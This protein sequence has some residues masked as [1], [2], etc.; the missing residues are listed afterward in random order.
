MKSRTFVRQNDASRVAR[1][2]NAYGG[3]QSPSKANKYLIQS[4]EVVFSS[5]QYSIIKDLV[6]TSGGIEELQ[7][8]HRDVP[9][10]LVVAYKENRILLI[11]QYRH[12]TKQTSFELPA[13]KTNPNENITQ[14][15]IR[16]LREE[17]GF[18][19]QDIRIIGHYYPISGLSDIEHYIT[20]ATHLKE[21]VPDRDNDEHIISQG[22]F[23]IPEVQKMILCGDIIDGPSIVGLN[24]F[25]LSKHG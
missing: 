12:Q 2:I 17:T 13:G 23:T 14:A 3:S 21:D 16:E 7:T 18:I 8:I 10:V 11:K 19:A 1:G 20:I 5:P 4:S 25:F 9:A 6:V 15:S 22:F 24:Y